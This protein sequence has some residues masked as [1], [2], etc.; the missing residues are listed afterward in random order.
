MTLRIKHGRL[1]EISNRQQLADLLDLPDETLETLLDSVEGEYQIFRIPKRSGGTRRIAAPSRRLLRCQRRITAYILYAVSPH[2]AAHGFVR[3]RGILE[4]ASAHLDKDL[5]LKLDLVDFFDSIPEARILGVFNDLGYG[6]DVARDLANLCCLGGSLPQ[7]AA[8]SPPLS[9]IVA[10][11]LDQR[12]AQLAEKRDLSYTRYADDLTF[13]GADLPP[14][15]IEVVS[16]N[17]CNE[18]FRVNAKK[19]RLIR[20]KR[21]RRVVTGISV[22][23]EQ[24]KVPREFKRRL[25]QEVHY[26][27]SYGYLSFAD[28]MKIENP[29]TYLDTLLGRLAFWHWVEPDNRFLERHYDD[30]VATCEEFKRIAIR[31]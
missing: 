20:T 12:L 17:I 11:G 21:G 2:S 9:N 26:V 28:R 8:T 16:R 22:A 24:P 3:Y 27:L 29:G 31:L 13:S 18:G 19:T 30:F 6:D 15:L 14:N 5:V 1:P 7:G 23:T 25:R 4:N 10:H